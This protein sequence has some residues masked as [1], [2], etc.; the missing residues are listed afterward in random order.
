LLPDSIQE[1]Y[2]IIKN[3]DFAIGKGKIKKYEGIE[4]DYR[5]YV[6]KKIHIKRPL[7]VVVD[8]GN[9]TAGPIV[10]KILREAGIDV[11]EQYCEIDFSFPHHEPNPTLLESIEALGKKVREVKADIG[12]GFDGDGDRLGVVDENGKVVWADQVVALLA[13]LILKEK[14]GAKIVFDVKCSR[15]LAEDI[16]AHGGVP[17]MWKTGHS[18]I[19]EKCQEIDASLG[20]ERSGHIF[21]R[22][23]YYSY[24]DAIFASL[25]LLEYLS[26]EKEKLSDILKTLPQY[27]SSPT[28]QVDC[29][30]EVKYKVVDEIT[31]QLKKKFGKRVIDINGARVEFDDGWG[32]VRASSNLPVLVLGFEAKTEKRLKE[33][34]NIF[35]EILKKFPEVGKEW[36]SG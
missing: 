35:R 27:V 32:I 30:D 21:F 9:G 29:P 13:R 10:P 31:K 28:W 16:K 34:E 15:A 12:L 24:D 26:G 33:I 25:K 17:V 19:K 20:G 36:R 4:N 11:V 14:P 1:L 22:E 8:C 18:Y 5:K 2:Q 3:G 23:D 6:L 7:K